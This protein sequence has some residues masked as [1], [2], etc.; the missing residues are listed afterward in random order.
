MA[1]GGILAPLNS[2][3]IAIALPELRDD[4][5]ISHGTIAWLISA[6]L[7]AMAVAQPAGGRLSDQLG[8]TRV[9]RFGLLAFLACSLGATLS[10]SFA[11]LVVFRTGQAIAG[12]VLI[13]NGMAILRESVPVEMLGQIN[14][15]NGALIG[16]SAAAGPLVGAGLLAFGSWRWLFL[17]NVPVVALA[18]LL[19]VWIPYKDRPTGER[20]EIDVRG[21]ALF[22]ALLIVV[23]LLLGSLRSERDVAV[24]GLL[25]ALAV[26]LGAA[27][28]W[29]QF[30][31]SLPVVQWRLFMIRSYAGATSHV[32]L[33]NLVMYTTLLTVPFFIREVQDG[34]STRS[35]L[36]LGAMS[37]LMAVIAPVSGRLADAVGRRWPA[38]VGSL[39]AV[40]ATLV[41]AVGLREDVAFGYLAFGLALLGL[42]VGLGFG[43]ATTA[44][45]ESA[46]RSLA[47]S[48]AGTN[49]MMRYVG[50]ILGA[51]I[52]AGILSTE[53]AIPG[54]D[55]F[56]AIMIVVVVV[57]A[58]SVVSATQIHLFPR[59]TYEDS[60]VG[61]AQRV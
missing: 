57:A 6:Y 43:S 9:Y 14:G 60:E 38:L 8:R 19:L 18:L 37:V 10:T 15:M 58:L 48:A 13:P 22:A 1:L 35:G 25:G 32:L 56:R 42:G 44:A 39:C 45:I 12:A 51:G 31:A 47:G 30:S 17:V 7:I 3:M 27:F 49:S 52:L 59:D 26:A 4:F 40:A 50:S 41:L 16:T 11:M 2:T 33:T 20:P 46:P 61:A 23:T 53:G 5:E 29:S 24:L 21:A 55:T 34:S 28:V 54:I 36:L